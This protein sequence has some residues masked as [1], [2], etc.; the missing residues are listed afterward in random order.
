MNLDDDAMMKW[1]T[2][3]CSLEYKQQISSYKVLIE[4]I[5]HGFDHYDVYMYCLWEIRT[6]YRNKNNA[7]KGNRT[8]K[9][10]AYASNNHQEVIIEDT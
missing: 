6:R 5:D 4:N 7:K 9:C 1:T 8:N 3:G 10:D 2:H